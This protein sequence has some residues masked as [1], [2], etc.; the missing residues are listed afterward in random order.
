MATGRLIER[1][2]KHGYV[3][4]LPADAKTG[5]RKQVWKSG[6]ATQKAAAAALRKALNDL[7][8]YGV[9]ADL[10]VAEYLDEWIE[11]AVEGKKAERT[12]DNYRNSCVHIKDAFG[13]VRLAKLK[14]LQIE[15]MYRTLAETLSPSSVHTVHRVL[16]AAMNRAVKWGYLRETPLARVDAPTL[17][18]QERQVLTVEQAVAVLA[19][20]RDNTPTSHV[21]AALAIY[22][23]LRRAEASGLRWSDVDVTAGVLHVRVTR[24]FRRGEIVKG[25]KSGKSRMIPIGE[26]LT[27][28]LKTWRA[29]QVRHTVRRGGTWSDADWVLRQPEGHPISPD[30]LLHELREAEVAAKVPQVSFHDLRHT[31]ATLLLEAGVDLK[32]VQDRL[33]HESI[34]TTG[35]TYAHVTG[36]MKRDAADK[37]D[38]SFRRPSKTNL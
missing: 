14:P 32:S 3:I 37:L 23:G 30:T 11:R 4:S 1:N 12:L 8:E 20:M 34:V 19:W 16:R 7:D 26:D 6:F 17:K 22:A 29:E 24:Q 5:K 38:D 10:T 36:R 28:I 27:Q 21:G 15:K 31:H 18:Q 33:G 13:D 25:T 2:G 35:N 9:P